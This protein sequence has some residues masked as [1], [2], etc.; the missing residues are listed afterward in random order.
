MSLEIVSSIELEGVLSSGL[1]NPEI[2]FRV[3]VSF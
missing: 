3:L 2:V 1:S